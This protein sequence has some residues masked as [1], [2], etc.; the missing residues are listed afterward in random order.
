M[1]FPHSTVNVGR[2][3]NKTLHRTHQPLPVRPP[4]RVDSPIESGSDIST[5]LRRVRVLLL[6]SHMQMDDN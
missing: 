4:G 1:S 3:F 2:M 5:V 6:I